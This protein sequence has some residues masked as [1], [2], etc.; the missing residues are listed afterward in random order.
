[1]MYSTRIS[2]THSSETYT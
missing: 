1:M 2:N